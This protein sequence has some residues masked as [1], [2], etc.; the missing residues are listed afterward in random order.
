LSGQKTDFKKHRGEDWHPQAPVDVFWF[1][2]NGWTF[3]GFFEDIFG[4]ICSEA[5]TL[6]FWSREK[7]HFVQGE[8]MTKKFGRCSDGKTALRRCKVQ[9]FLCL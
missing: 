8:G 6:T 1:S 5:K 9:F 3:S 4:D 7:G 2:R